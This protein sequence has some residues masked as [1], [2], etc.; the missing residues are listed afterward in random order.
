VPSQ[1][2]TLINTGYLIGAAL[3]IG[4]GDVEA[5]LGVRAEKQ[6]LEN[7]AKPLTAET[8]PQAGYAKSPSTRHARRRT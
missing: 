4:G 2:L 1:D 8:A 5:L 6:T 3:M 7:I